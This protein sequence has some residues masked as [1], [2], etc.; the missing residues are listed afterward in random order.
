MGELKELKVLLLF[1]VTIMIFSLFVIPI[2]K[3]FNIKNEDLAAMA[4]FGWYLMCFILALVWGACVERRGC[5]FF[6]N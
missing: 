1:M 5:W 2:T 4:Y 6:S 3:P